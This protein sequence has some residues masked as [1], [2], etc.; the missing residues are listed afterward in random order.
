[1][2]K[3]QRY[4]SNSAEYFHTLHLVFYLMVS[5]PL[6]LFCWVYLRRMGQGG[7]AEGFSFGAVHG[8]VVAGMALSGWLAYTAYRKRFDRYDISQPFRERLRFFH[9]TAWLKYGWLAVAN[10]LPVVGLYLTGEQFFVALYAVALV[11]FSI[12][13][14]TLKRVSTDLKLT[15]AEQERLAGEQD[16]DV[17]GA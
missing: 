4:L 2:A 16:L 11:L 17:N 9:Q 8:A 3:Q 7:L 13:R 6:L 10:L 12:N 1:M 5:V 14:P 15:T